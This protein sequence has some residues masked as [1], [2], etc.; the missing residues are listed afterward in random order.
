M[1][2]PGIPRQTGIPIAKETYCFYDGGKS[3]RGPARVLRR[4][5]GTGSYEV[6]CFK[7]PKK[8]G[9]LF[10]MDENEDF[11]KVNDE[12]L[13]SVLEAPEVVNRGSRTY[14]RFPQLAYM[15]DN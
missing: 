7:F 14:Y 10:T 6:L 12:E 1:K 8:G 3:D 4:E 15:L 9:G 11:W 2:V 13:V 5:D